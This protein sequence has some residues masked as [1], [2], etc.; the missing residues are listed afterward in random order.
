MSTNQTNHWLPVMGGPY[1]GNDY[2][3]PDAPTPNSHVQIASEKNGH[4]QI[5][6]D[7]KS[8]EWVPETE[9][10]RYEKIER[11]GITE[12]GGG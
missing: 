5:S 6:E 10:A 4:Y 2:Y 8:V 3:P 11:E 1:S 12:F 9:Q 7:G